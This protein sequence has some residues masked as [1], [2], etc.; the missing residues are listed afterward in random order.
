MI[1]FLASDVCEKVGI[2]NSADVFK[3]NNLING[4]DYLKFAP[5]TNPRAFNQLVNLGHVSRNTQS[6][7]LFTLIGLLEVIFKSKLP[8]ARAF[9]DKLL[10][11][12]EYAIYESVAFQ[13]VSKLVWGMTESKRE[14]FF[15]DEAFALNFIRIA[16]A[17]GSNN[18]TDDT[19][20]S[21]ELI[22]SFH[23]TNIS[24]EC[25]LPEVDLRFLVSEFNGFSL[26]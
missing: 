26:V 17:G 21:V 7:H 1:Y 12:D 22:R 19:V 13:T 25:V 3:S 8:Q 4:R 14:K 10:N 16:V 20:K 18:M 11:V 9:K 2:R 15:S 5:K 24:N 6:L 23:K